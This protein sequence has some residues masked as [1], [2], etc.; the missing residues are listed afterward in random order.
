MC[1]KLCIPHLLKADNPH[2]LT[3]SPPLD[4]FSQGVNW[5]APHSAYTIAKYG[6]TLCAYGMAEEFEDEGIA[7]N[8]LWPR[9][10]ISTA[11][12]NNLLGGGGSMS[13]TRVP[14]I[15]GDSAYHIL[16]SE[17]TST[18]GN[19]Y[20]DD[21]ILIS[22]GAMELSKYATVK[23]TKDEELLPDYFC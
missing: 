16:T 17:S 1:S 2:I 12:V 13:M 14:Q 3:I 10:A 11:A 4:I 15:M 22:K 19:F 8:T 6:M 20:M 23:G 5:F 7:V 9:T 21:E 18:T